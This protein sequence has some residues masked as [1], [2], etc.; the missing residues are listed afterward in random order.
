MLRSLYILLIGF[1]LLSQD[2]LAQ[3]ILRCELNRSD[4]RKA[5]V[6]ACMMFHNE[7]RFLKEWLEYH[8]SIGV[9]HFYLY[10][11]ASTDEFWPLLMPYVSA[12][13]VE[14]FDLHEMSPTVYVHN[15]LQKQVYNHAVNLAKGKND[16]LAILDADEFICM[17][18]HHDLR[19]FLKDYKYA[20][21]LVIN[22]VMYGSSNIEEL[23][24]NDLQIEHFLYRA[25]DD[26]H[27]HTLYKSIVQP[28]FVTK[29]GIHTCTCYPKTTVFANHERFSH[30]PAFK[31]P[32]IDQIRINHYWW[33]DEKF[34]REVKRPLR[35]GWL[36]GYSDAEVDARRN[37][38]NSVYDP[39]MLP[40]V[41][42]VKKRLKTQTH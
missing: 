4:K 37:A 8:K 22:W 27:E 6:A 23:G 38:F 9:T 30:T 21:C 20:T 5:P 3:P 33:R 29:A 15:D 32:P 35:A 12:G 39:S 10:N 16:W 25:P 36:S 34:F 11:N 28:L 13:E 17:P 7:A 40:F 24:P 41:D 1:C 42:A 14:L 2:L 31:T 18:H 26:W 19:K